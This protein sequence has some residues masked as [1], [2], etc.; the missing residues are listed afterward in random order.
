M[1]RFLQLA[2]LLALVSCS[3]TRVLREDE[4]RL[5]RNSVTIEGQA[6]GLTPGM[7]S[8]YIKQEANGR[9]IMGW[10]PFLYMYNWSRRDGFCHKIG[11]APVVYSK[12]AAGASVANITTRLNY[13]G[14]YNSVVDTVVTVK[15]RT[16]FV[17]Y[18]VKPGKQYPIESISYSL[19]AGEEFRSEFQKDTANVLRKLMGQ[20][21]SEQLLEEESSRSAAYMRDLGYFTFNKNY[22]AFEADTLGGKAKLQY[23]IQEYT[24]SESPDN[25]TPIEKYR[26]GRVTISRPEG[27]KLRSK[28]LRGLNTIKPGEL[29]SATTVNNTYSRLSALRV[30]SGVSIEMTPV[31]GNK[32]D[33][34][35]NLTP[36]PLQGFKVNMEASTNS[37]GL[38]GVSPKLNYFHRSLFRGGEWFNIG[39]TGAFQFKL[40]DDTRATEYGVTAGLSLPRFLGLPY[41]VFK[42]A[43][44]PRTEFNGAFNYQNRPEYTRTV[45]STSFGYSGM[46]IKNRVSYQI[47]PLQLN[48]VRLFDLDAAFSSSLDRNPYMRYAFQDHLDAGVGGIFYYNSSKDIVPQGS[49]RFRRLALDVSGNVLSLFKSAMPVNADGAAMIGGSP[50][51]QYVRAEY[52][53][54]KT[55][56]YG[57]ND[58]KAIATRLLIGGGYAYGNSSALPYEKQFYAGGASSMRGWQA[59]ALGPGG[60]E[61][62]KTFIIPSQTGGVKLEANIEYRFKMVWKLEG[63]LFADLGNVWN[64]QGDDTSGP[65]YFRFKDFYK[66]LGA[67]WGLGLRVNLEFIL[68]RLDWGLKMY[69]PSLE[70][71]S[72]IVAPQDWLRRGGSALHFGIGY[73]F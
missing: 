23:K 10:N 22:Y 9:G 24:R 32:V 41:R 71:G 64:I 11:Q 40:D 35:I 17:N 13:L 69:D 6:D 70:E 2:V 3:T 37:S 65:G 63:A 61:A 25:A 20:R 49:Y 48:F 27:M 72:R 59:R 5:A 39:F 67:D 43:S 44:V 42:R 8:P 60:E 38:I 66:G 45:I 57:F 14:Y 73:P 19:P 28:V 68:L 18:T 4:Y 21:L 7:L 50:F 30:F 26:F 31:E 51:A 53:F 12:D 55:W 56:R 29:Y 52:S 16:V 46:F 1:R 58:E 33:A 47:Y 34:A 54:G 62:D 36:A 15:G